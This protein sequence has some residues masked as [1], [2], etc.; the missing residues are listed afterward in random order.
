[1]TSTQ[2]IEAQ[3]ESILKNL[4]IKYKKFEIDPDFA[5]TTAFCEKY[6]YSM[7]ESGNTILVA[8]KR[9]VKKFCACIVKA[10][11][12]LDVNHTVKRLMEVSRV[13]FA[14]PD[15]TR[16]VTGMMIGGVTPFALPD[17]MPIYVDQQ[18]L[19]LDSV[20][21]GSGSRS[22]KLIMAPAELEKTPNLQFIEGLAMAPRD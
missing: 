3:V 16:E 8:S 9:G 2:E 4:G 17:D 1:M 12:R 19:A 13:S 7:E 20:I 11:D 6:G 18:I 15:D 21:L 22:S 5:D 14:S 10:T